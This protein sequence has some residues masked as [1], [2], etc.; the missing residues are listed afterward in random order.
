VGIT[1]CQYGGQAGHQQQQ[2]LVHGRKASPDEKEVGEV[3]L[4]IKKTLNQNIT[5]HWKS[6]VSLAQEKRRTKK[7]QLL[8]Q[9][10]HT[11]TGKDKGI[12]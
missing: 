2:Q 4:P 11:S 5:F 8:K 1:L 10:M 7:G 12:Y 9:I 3:S 6:L